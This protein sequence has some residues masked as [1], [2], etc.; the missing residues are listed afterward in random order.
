VRLIQ[1]EKGIDREVGIRDIYTR[2]PA[3]LFISCVLLVN[4]HKTAQPSLYTI[5]RHLMNKEPGDEI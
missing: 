5:T 1:E 4:V 2:V 3:I